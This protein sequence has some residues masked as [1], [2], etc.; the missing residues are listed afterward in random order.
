MLSPKMEKALNDQI[1][2]EF[3]SSYLY[4]SMSAWFAS[5]NLMGMAHWMGLQAKEEWGHGMKIY[6][7]VLERGGTVTL[8]AIDAPP[9]EFK[10]PLAIFE[11]AYGHEQKVTGLINDLADTAAEEND[12]ATAIML[13]WFIS[14]QVEEEA[15]ALEI[16]EKLKLIQDSPNGLFMMDS[17]LGRRG[18]D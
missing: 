14:E 11:A 12:K 17:V 3:Y 2:A 5:E 4:L 15:S 10:S 6:D 9:A 18:S 7:F 16:V 8:G 13:Q 1:T